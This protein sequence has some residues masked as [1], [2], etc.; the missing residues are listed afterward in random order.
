MF[1]RWPEIK[2]PQSA[3]MLSFFLKYFIYWTTMMYNSLIRNRFWPLIFG[4]SYYSVCYICVKVHLSWIKGTLD[5]IA[6]DEGLSQK[7]F[8]HSITHRALEYFCLKFSAIPSSLV[9]WMTILEY[10]PVEN[11]W[12]LFIFIKALIKSHS[13]FLALKI[14]FMQNIFFLTLSSK[15]LSL[16]CMFSWFDFAVFLV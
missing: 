3:M 1:S 12:N 13:C 11:I 16:Y 10:L 4:R 14:S 6:R 9:V 7:C 8:L 15:Y 5:L 2:K